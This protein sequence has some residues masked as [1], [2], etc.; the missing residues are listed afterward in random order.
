MAAASD[1]PYVCTLNK[2]LIKKAEK[3]L[4]EKAKYRAKDIQHLR[5]M[6]NAHPGLH[7]DKTYFCLNTK[8][9]VYSIIYS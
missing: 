2:D 3:E 8:S 1:T 5:D 4:N 6:I 9:F 7:V